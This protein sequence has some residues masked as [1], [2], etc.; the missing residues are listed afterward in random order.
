[1]IEKRAEQTGPMRYIDAGFERIDTIPNGYI[2]TSDVPINLS[3][4]TPDQPYSVVQASRKFDG[5]YLTWQEVRHMGETDLTG[6]EGYLVGADMNPD[7]IA[8]TIAT[9]G[10][11]ALRKLNHSWKLR[12]QVEQAL[13]GDPATP[14]ALMYLSGTLGMMLARLRAQAHNP[15]AQELRTNLYDALPADEV[16]YDITGLTGRQKVAIGTPADPSKLI[17]HVNYLDYGDPNDPLTPAG[18]S[19]SIGKIGSPLTRSA[20]NRMDGESFQRAQTNLMRM[21]NNSYF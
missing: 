21:E 11:S 19:L 5:P 14:E 12:S 7:E 2:L 6:A 13:T 17:Q 10:E 3:L 18:F 1:M 9:M 16:W 20:L 4:V 15:I 8:A